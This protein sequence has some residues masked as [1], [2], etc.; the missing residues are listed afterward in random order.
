MLWI[1][2]VGSSSEQHI[3]H[4]E[5][6][7]PVNISSQFASVA[8]ATEVRSPLQVHRRTYCAWQPKSNMVTRTLTQRTSHQAII[9]SRAQLGK[10][11]PKAPH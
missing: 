8:N 6:P 7:D 10:D 1:T 3:L 2:G 11:S 9:T 4:T 5:G